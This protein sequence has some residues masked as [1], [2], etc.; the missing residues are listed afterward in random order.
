MPCGRVWPWVRQLF[1]SWGKSHRRN[2]LSLFSHEQQQELGEWL[3]PSWRGGDGQPLP[4]SAQHVTHSCVSQLPLMSTGVE[5]GTTIYLT[6]CL[7]QVHMYLLLPCKTDILSNMRHINNSWFLSIYSVP[8]ILLCS[9]HVLSYLIFKTYQLNTITI[10]QMRTL[11]LC[12]VL[13]EHW[14]SWIKLSS[15]RQ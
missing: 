8:G 5:R 12:S 7:F 10:C 1:S 13:T 15:C 4:A 14:W 3:L 6:P 2:Q 11:K 9:L